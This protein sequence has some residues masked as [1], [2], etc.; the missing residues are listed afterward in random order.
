M[1]SLPTPVDFS[2]QQHFTGPDAGDDAR[3][4]A[5]AHWTDNYRAGLAE[6]DA[7]KARREV[8]GNLD[9]L[10]RDVNLLVDLLIDQRNPANA[11]PRSTAN[12]IASTRRRIVER[13]ERTAQ[14]M[15]ALA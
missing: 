2:D 1:S 14:A 4:E 9:N 6:R 11:F 15:C 5:A 12:D 7:Q 8:K 13:L 3:C 10:D